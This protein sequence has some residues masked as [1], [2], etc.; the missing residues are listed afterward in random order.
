MTTNMTQPARKLYKAI[1]VLVAAS[2]EKMGVLSMRFEFQG[3]VSNLALL[4][5]LSKYIRSFILNT[6]IISNN[7]L[8]ACL[9]RKEF[10]IVN[11][12][13]CYD[14]LYFV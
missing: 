2:S 4:V 10:A 6:S 3:N 12:K 1:Q 7:C 8:S 13:Q 11:L 14:L 5:N 9:T